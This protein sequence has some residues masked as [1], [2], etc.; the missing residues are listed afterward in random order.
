LNL[1]ALADGEKRIARGQVIRPGH[2]LIVTSAEV[3][4]VKDGRETLCAV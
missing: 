3:F 2:T 1:L 4:T